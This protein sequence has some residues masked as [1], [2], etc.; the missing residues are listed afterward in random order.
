MPRRTLIVLVSLL[1]VGMA[2]WFGLNAF[3]AFKDAEFNPVTAPG[4]YAVAP[5]IAELH[6]E[7]FVSD[8]HADTLLWRRNP[9]QR[10]DFGHVDLPRLVDGGVALQVFGLVTRV[11]A[12]QNFDSNP[13]DG[14]DRMVALAAAQRWPLDTWFDPLAR[15]HFQMQRLHAL[16]VDSEG[17][18]LVIET[19]RDLE[20]L[21]ERRT[22]GETVVG[23]LLAAEGAH[24]DSLDELDALVDGG[25][26]MLG[27]A[28]FFDNTVAGSAHGEAKGGLTD[29]GRRVIPA[30]E[31][32]GVVIDLAH[33]S[34][35][36]FAE[37]AALATRPVVVSHT[38][39]RGTCDRI[40][41]LSDDQLW[42][43]AKTR[44]VVG[45]ALFPEAVCGTDLEAT[46]KAIDHAVDIIGVDHVGLGSDFDGTVLTPVD[47]A[48]LPLITAGLVERGYDR[49]AIEKIMGGNVWRVLRATLPE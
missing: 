22:R 30:A 41:N 6:G 33:A 13:T 27:L 26:R 1:V 19:R 28:H 9:L 38:G 4:P 25:L 5:E 20:A 49:D 37:A 42:A 15:A 2:L 7:F 29:F 32:R 18:L 10:H 17:T 48:G 35:R 40:R 24:F 43:V 31:A 14:G 47:V 16:E 23:G 36:A 11:P 44:G 45:I 8:L 12:G 21:V 34:P 46:L 3:C 39:V